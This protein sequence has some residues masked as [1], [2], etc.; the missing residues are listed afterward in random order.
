M[1]VTYAIR[2]AGGLRHVEL[3]GASR[4]RVVTHVGSFNKPQNASHA[5]YRKL[6]RHGRRFASGMVQKQFLLYIYVL[7]EEDVKYFVSELEPFFA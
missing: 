1:R 2:D 6:V 7:I 3:V 5:T 4:R